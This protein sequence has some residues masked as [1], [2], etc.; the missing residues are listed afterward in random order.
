MA[1]PVEEMVRVN[2][3]TERFKF[4]QAIV[5]S[6]AGSRTFRERA[7]MAS[8]AAAI[9]ASDG[10]CTSVPVITASEILTRFPPPYDL[11][12]IDIEGGEYDFLTAYKPVWTA[13]ASVVLEWHSWH[14]GGG[15]AVQLREELE[16]GGFSVT[17]SSTADA[18]PAMPSGET[19][20]MLLVKRPT[21]CPPPS[22][23]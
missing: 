9:G 7:V 16:Q 3:L 21:R 22:P 15:G 19:G 14:P 11:I 23:P 1:A 20:L 5:A 12:K 4:L 10:R 18:N 8:S 17:Y 6:G 13:A 2:G